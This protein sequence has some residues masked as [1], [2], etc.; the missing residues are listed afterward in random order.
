MKRILVCLLALIAIFGLTGCKDKKECT[1]DNCKKKTEKAIVIPTSK[2]GD[3]DIDF[4]NEAEFH[5]LKY[6]YP[7]TATYQDIDAY[8][9]ID[10]LV[11]GK[12]LYRI[13][14]YFFED[15]PVYQVMQDTTLEKIGTVRAKDSKIEWDLYEGKEDD[16]DISMLVLFYNNSTYNITFTSD[17]DINEFMSAFMSTINIEK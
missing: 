11:D 9:M 7:S 4:E 16:R 5:G 3:I 10:Q 13:G 14:L 12:V 2:I 6:R 1:G 17:Y 8:T 15:M